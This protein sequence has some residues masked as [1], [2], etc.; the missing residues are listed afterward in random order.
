MRF[1]GGRGAFWGSI[2]GMLFGG[3]FFLIPAI[4]PIVVMGPLAV[5]LVGA[6][7]GAALGGATG[8]L[9]AAL[10]SV[11]IPKDSVVKYDAE[12]KAGKFL[13]LANGTPEMLERARVVLGTVDPSFLAAHAA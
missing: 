13:V 1:W 6:L 4:G 11:G 5:W 2:W 12:V 3:A 10:T 7:E 9:A 8:A